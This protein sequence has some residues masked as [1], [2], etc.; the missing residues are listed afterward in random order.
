MYATASLQLDNAAMAVI[1][2]IE[3]NT[4]EIVSPSHDPTWTLVHCVEY[5][6]CQNESNPLISELLADD[7]F[8]VRQSSILEEELISG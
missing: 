4:S 2:L 6:F 8:L 3:P 5:L 7:N 1:P